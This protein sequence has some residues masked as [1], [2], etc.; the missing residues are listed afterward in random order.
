MNR[1]IKVPPFYPR[2]AVVQPAEAASWV[3]GATPIEEAE[4]KDRMA[5]FRGIAKRIM[6]GRDE[7]TKYG[8]NSDTN[9]EIARAMEWAFQAGQR[10]EKNGATQS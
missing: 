10:S 6:G 2:L 3:L 9:G 1:S 5:A 7:R 4:K 8:F